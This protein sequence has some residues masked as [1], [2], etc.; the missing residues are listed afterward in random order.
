MKLTA[1]GIFALV[2]LMLGASMGA[3]QTGHDL[4]SPLCG[5]GFRVIHLGEDGPSMP[6]PC[7]IKGCHAGCPRRMFDAA[8]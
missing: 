8:Q 4:L 7:P 5:G 3:A 2:P 6:P 1:L